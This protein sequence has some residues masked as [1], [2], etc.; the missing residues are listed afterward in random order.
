[1]S[2]QSHAVEF[3]QRLVFSHI[4][5]FFNKWQRLLLFAP[6]RIFSR[7]CWYEQTSVRSEK[8][9]RISNTAMHS[10]LNIYY[11]VVLPPCE[12]WNKRPHFGF[13][14]SLHIYAIVRSCRDEN[15]TCCCW[16]SR[17]D[18]A[19]LGGALNALLLV[20]LCTCYVDVAKGQ[21]TDPSEGNLMLSC[22]Q[23]IFFICFIGDT[24]QTCKNWSLDSQGKKC[25]EK[26]YA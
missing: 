25:S 14:I 26:F 10:H 21:N 3:K 8:L 12:E 5:V 13:K 17:S 1:M 23:S 19:N 16:I 6:G 7:G 9:M 22:A 20:V 24:P 11:Q 2:F 4:L 15:L 18:M